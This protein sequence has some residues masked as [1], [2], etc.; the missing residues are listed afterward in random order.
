ML[1]HRT[2]PAESLRLAQRTLERKQMPSDTR[3]A[4]AVV[5]LVA[6]PVLTAG[7]ICCSLADCIGQERVV[8][9]YF[10]FLMSFQ[11]GLSEKNADCKHALRSSLAYTH[12][13]TN[14]SPMRHVL[15]LL[16]VKSDVSSWSLSSCNTVYFSLILEGGLHSGISKGVYHS[17]LGFMYHSPCLFIWN[18]GLHAWLGV[19]HLFSCT[20]RT[21]KPIE[22]TLSLSLLPPNANDL[23]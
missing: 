23:C 10:S 6:E 1:S 9:A 18:E 20:Q 21:V 8:T 3:W 15:A 17:F 7:S 22:N 13:H 2:E 11:D 14:S 19:E 4:W 5:L 16:A 12:S